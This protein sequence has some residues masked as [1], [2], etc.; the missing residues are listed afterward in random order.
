[1]LKNILKFL[2]RLIKLDTRD[3]YMVKI[4]IRNGNKND[5]KIGVLKIFTDRLYP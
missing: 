2:G 3:L 5:K 4:Y 1:M